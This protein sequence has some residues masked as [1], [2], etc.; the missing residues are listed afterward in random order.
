MSR[1]RPIGALIICRLD[2]FGG[3]WLSGDSR[4]NHVLL[5]DLAD[6]EMY[7]TIHVAADVAAVETE[8][9]IFTEAHDLDLIRSQHRRS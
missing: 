1:D 9:A 7:P 3:L 4:K 8:R 2:R 5:A 6:F